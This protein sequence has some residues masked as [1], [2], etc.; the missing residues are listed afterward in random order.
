MPSFRLL[1]ACGAQYGIKGGK[2]HD[3]YLTIYIRYGYN[4]GKLYYSR[5][6]S[7]LPAYPQEPRRSVRGFGIA[8][9]VLNRNDLTGGTAL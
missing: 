6:V 1:Q 2:N 5:S 4:S 9:T 8:G 7:N 3:R